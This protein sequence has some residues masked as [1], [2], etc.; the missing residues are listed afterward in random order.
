MGATKQTASA[1][2]PNEQRCPLVSFL[3]S[4]ASK[5]DKNAD[6]VLA[7]EKDKLEVISQQFNLEVTLPASNR[8]GER[9]QIG[10]Q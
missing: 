9:V 5:L 1:G 8:K 7:L 3:Q 4:V 2:N 6:L 10:E